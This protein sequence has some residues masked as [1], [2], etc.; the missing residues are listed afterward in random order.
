MILF[1]ILPTSSYVAIGFGVLFGALWLSTV[2]P[3]SGIIFTSIWN[4]ICSNAIWNSFF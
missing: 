3:T 4:K 1:L 2:P